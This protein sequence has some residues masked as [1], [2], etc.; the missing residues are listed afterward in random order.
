MASITE[1][2]KGSNPA[3][4]PKDEER[5]PPALPPIRSFREFLKDAYDTEKANLEPASAVISGF[6]IGDTHAAI[7]ITLLASDGN[8]DMA[9]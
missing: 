7:S 8:H 5:K 4:A 2:I 9:A 1:T 6:T 3:A